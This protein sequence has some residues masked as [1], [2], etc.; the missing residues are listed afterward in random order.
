M[1]TFVLPTRD[2]LVDS[3]CTI[4]VLFVLL[5]SPHVCLRVNSYFICILGTGEMEAIHALFTKH[6]KN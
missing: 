4:F 3:F 6:F 1:L 5:S 2:Q